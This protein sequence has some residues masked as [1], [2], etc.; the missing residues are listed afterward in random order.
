MRTDHLWADLRFTLHGRERLAERTDMSEA[1]V[2]AALRENR[3]VLITQE[4]GSNLLSLLHFGARDGG[5][6]I[7]VFD[8]K[9]RQ[10][11]TVISI[12]HWENLRAK[13]EY[14]NRRGVKVD[15]LFQA[16]RLSDPGHELLRFPPFCGGNAFILRARAPRGADDRTVRIGDLDCGEF[17]RLPKREAVRRLQAMTEDALGAGTAPPID[18]FWGADAKTGSLSHNKKSLVVEDD[19]GYEALYRA[20][21]DDISNRRMTGRKYPVFEEVALRNRPSPE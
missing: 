4:T 11:V 14:R 21:A 2:A 10:V 15:D 7:M 17:L 16:V 1:D 8:V 9:D 18:V 6:F 13:P 19:D 5:F 12:D 3:F 20:L